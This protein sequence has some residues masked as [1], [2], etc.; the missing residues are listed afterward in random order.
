MDATTHATPTLA[1]WFECMDS[2][3]P[4]RVLDMITA[5]FRMSVQFSKGEGASAE[6]VGDRSGLVGYLAQREK[7]TLIHV[8]DRG[9]TVDGVEL[10]L[11]RT[12]RDG[13]FE[14]SFNASAQ[15]TGDG[16]VRRLLIGRTPEIA[17]D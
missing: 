6:F 17:F 5:D 12:T 14:A 16:K 4:D 11:G 3:D 7:S 8:I 1:R 9:V 13:A 2:D 10:V 15:I